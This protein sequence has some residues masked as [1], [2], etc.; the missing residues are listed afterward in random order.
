[1]DQKIKGQIRQLVDNV[2]AYVIAGQM[3]EGEDTDCIN[4]D[5]APFVLCAILGAKEFRAEFLK[6]LDDYDFE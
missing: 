4:G 2:Y 3:P 6:A 1:M 5:D